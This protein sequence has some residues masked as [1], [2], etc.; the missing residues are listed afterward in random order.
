M[1]NIRVLKLAKNQ[2]GD[3]GCQIIAKMVLSERGRENVKE[4]DISHN[5]ITYEG[6]YHLSIVMVLE[7]KLKVLRISNN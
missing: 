4:I 2:I 3:I 5:N 7:S 6:F 1:P